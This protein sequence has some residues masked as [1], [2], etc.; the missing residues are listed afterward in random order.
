MKSQS[1]AKPYFTVRAELLLWVNETLKVPL[2]TLDSLTTG[3]AFCFIFEACFRGSIPL[4]RVKRTPKHEGEVQENF[5]ILQKTMEKRKTGRT[6]HAE[7]LMK[8]RRLD[9]IEFLNWLK[10]HWE[11]EKDKENAIPVKSRKPPR[12]S[13]VGRSQEQF[14]LT[15]GKMRI[16]RDFYFHKLRRIEL[17]LNDIGAK[18]PA[19]ELSLIHI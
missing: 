9:T 15:L 18:G 8:G 5:K 3:T 11:A 10:Q 16:E 14:E 4:D 6:F 13:S 19:I 17:Y 7:R 1:I 2:D 12:P